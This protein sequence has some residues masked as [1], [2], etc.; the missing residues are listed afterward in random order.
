VSLW[1]ATGPSGTWGRVRRISFKRSTE[2]RRLAPFHIPVTAHKQGLAE[3]D[4]TQRSRSFLYACIGAAAADLFGLSDV[5]FYENGVTSVNLPLCGQEVGGRATRTTHPQALHGF[6]RILSLVFDRPFRVENGF[7]WQTKQ[8][9]LELLKRHRKSDLAKTAVSCSHTRQITH[10]S[11]HCG[12][13]SQCLARRVASLGAAMGEDDPS[14]GYRSDPLLHERTRDEERIL[15]E[16][17]IGQAKAVVGMT[18]A[19]E[20]TRRYAGELSRVYPYLNMPTPA[21]AEKLFELHLRHARQVTDSVIGQVSLHADDIVHGR[22]GDTS[23]LAYAVGTGRTP[24][25]QTEVKT[26]DPAEGL[27]KDPVAVAADHVPPLLEEETFTVAHHGIRHTFGGRSKQSFAL[28]A[29]L[30]RRPGAQVLFDHLR[31]PGDVW[32]GLDVED[33][34]IRGAVMR[35]K[36]EL[37]KGG[38]NE[39][40]DTLKTVSYKNRAYAIL[41]WPPSAEE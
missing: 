32:D 12:M 18:A 11:P 22:L 37:R 17:F 27:V 24:R 7:L 20:F 16:R 35:L 23:G 39:L 25:R 29:R 19:R 30:A 28:L 1:S 38:L 15:A 8:D 9:V 5:W 4:F 36:V 31:Q 33:E 2:A 10:A 41:E 3:E 40:A 26:S 21:T 13:C 6:G 34:T 14:A